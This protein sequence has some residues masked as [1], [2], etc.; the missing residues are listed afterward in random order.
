MNHEN[1]DHFEM[2]AQL[3]KFR[4]YLLLLAKIMLQIWMSSHP[5]MD[6]QNIQCP[7]WYLSLH[8]VH[9]ERLKVIIIVKNPFGLA[10]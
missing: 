6:R 2:Y 1:A 7:F 8:Y 4:N 10:F 9:K 3:V 5:Y